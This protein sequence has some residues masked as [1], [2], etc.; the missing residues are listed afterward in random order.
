MVVWFRGALLGWSGQKLWKARES[1]SLEL[2]VVLW[3]CG[4]STEKAKAL[5]GVQEGRQAV[6]CKSV[7]GWDWS[8]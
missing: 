6:P 4:G 2:Q 1:Q 7:G 8:R 3:F 5:P